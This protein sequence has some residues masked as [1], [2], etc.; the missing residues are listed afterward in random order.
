M[1]EYKIPFLFLIFVMFLC[2]CT[3]RQPEAFGPYLQVVVF[4]DGEEREIVRNPLTYV[5]E[6]EILTPQNEKLLYTVWPDSLVGDT[7]LDQRNIV[8]IASLE[9]HGLVG[10]WIRQNLSEDA[11][12]EVLNHQAYIFVKEDLWA[13]GQLVIIFTAPQPEM[14]SAQILI[15]GEE[16]FDICDLSINKRMEKWL[17]EPLMGKDE[18]FSEESE[19]LEKFGFQIRVPPNFDL[20]K[21]E[22]DGHFLWL[23]HLEPEQ[24]VFVWWED[25]PDSNLTVEWWMSK[26]DSLCA[27]YYEGDSVI[28]HRVDYEETYF[29]SVYA[30]QIRGLWKNSTSLLG[31]PLVSYLFYDQVKNRKYIVDAAVFAAGTRKA[32]YLRH[33]RVIASTFRANPKV[34]TN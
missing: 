17:F 15:H 5:L 6:R 25:T 34:K 27:V 19:I 20:E 12:A 18:K 13:E 24:W 9:S 2:S 28:A 29:D 21:V 11:R 30:L 16:I 26:R 33:T 8:M 7:Y 31:G 23:R 32:P 22:P 3:E 4:S 10:N 14:L 1:P